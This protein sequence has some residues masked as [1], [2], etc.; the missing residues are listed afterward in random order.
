MRNVGTGRVHAK[1]NYQVRANNSY[2]HV[3]F[4]IGMSQIPS[5]IVMNSEAMSKIFLLLSLR[6]DGAFSEYVR[7]SPTL[8]NVNMGNE[9]EVAQFSADVQALKEETYQGLRKAIA[10]IDGQ[11]ETGEKEED[12]FEGLRDEN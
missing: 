10:S 8:G 5:D 4:E 11:E 9:V 2:E 1:R 12:N 3:T 6:L 7:N